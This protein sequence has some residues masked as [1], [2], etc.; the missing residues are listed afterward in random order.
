MVVPARINAAAL[1]TNGLCSK[2]SNG[3]GKIGKSNYTSLALHPNPF[4]A[5]FVPFCVDKSLDMHYICSKCQFHE[6]V[7]P[8]TYQCLWYS[9]LYQN[10]Y[11][12]ILQRCHLNPLAPIPVDLIIV[13]ASCRVQAPRN[14]LIS[15]KFSWILRSFT[16]WSWSK[17]PS[18]SN[19]S[20]TVPSNSQ[21]QF[22]DPAPL[23]VSSWQTTSKS[24]KI[25]AKKIALPW[26][27]TSLFILP[28]C[29]RSI[30]SGTSPI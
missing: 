1:Q 16:S 23:P 10:K 22:W 18:S 20:V 29:L 13:N 2:C 15:S 17:N 30:F 28:C 6:K 9:Y 4:C 5:C 14:H 8:A 12:Q 21:K 7:I 19:W 25:T 11:W 3:D 27:S 24:W 26:V